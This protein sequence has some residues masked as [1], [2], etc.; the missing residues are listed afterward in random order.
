VHRKSTHTDPG[1]NFPWA[2]FMADVKA[3]MPDARRWELRLMA[4]P[5]PSAK[6]RKVVDK[7]VPAG[8]A[9]LAARMVTFSSRVAGKFARLTAER[10]QP[11]IRI[12]RVK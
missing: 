11:V 3:L 8:R 6:V 9:K 7:S 5:T 4:L 1:P 10:R 12:V 2:K